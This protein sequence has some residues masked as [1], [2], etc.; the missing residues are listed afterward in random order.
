MY[1][2]SLDKHVY[3]VSLEEGRELWRFRARGAVTAPPGRGRGPAVL[4]G[5][6]RQLLRPGRR[7]GRRAVEVRGASGWY[8]ARALVV[9]GAVYAASL[10]GSV[11][12]L[13]ADTG[14]LLWVMETDGPIIGSPA[15]VG[16]FLVVASDDGRL[17]TATLADGGGTRECHIAHRLRTNLVGHDGRVYLGV[18]DHTV[19]SDPGQRRQRGGHAGRGLGVQDQ[20]VPGREPGLGRPLVGAAL[21][22]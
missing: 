20:Q 16:D 9:G 10:D 13:S 21:L 2:G 14:S 6:R 12:A 3:A 18:W 15:A 4:R 11:Y 22:S 7:L 17:R 5:V 8:W 19:R 1:F